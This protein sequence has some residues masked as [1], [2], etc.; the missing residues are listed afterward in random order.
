MLQGGDAG[1][2]KNIGLPPLAKAIAL[3]RECNCDWIA[4]ACTFDGTKSN[5]KARQNPK[6]ILNGIFWEK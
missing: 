5:A 2:A 1:N 6:F 3:L 4:I